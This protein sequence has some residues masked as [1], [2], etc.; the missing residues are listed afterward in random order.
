M[1]MRGTVSKTKQKK[2]EKKFFSARRAQRAKS[3][4]L[5]RALLQGRDVA[6]TPHR[7]FHGWELQGENG[8]RN[9]QMLHAD[10]FFLL[11]KKKGKKKRKKREKERKKKATPAFLSSAQSPAVLCES[12]VSIPAALC[13]VGGSA[14]SLAPKKVLLP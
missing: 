12:P 1:W 13:W 3:P 7:L 5:G 11:V 6:L 4:F 8:F 2:R 14:P 9:L 10:L